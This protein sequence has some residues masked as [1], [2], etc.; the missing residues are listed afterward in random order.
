[1]S[2]M[3]L[4]PSRLPLILI[5]LLALG[6][7]LT[8]AQDQPKACGSEI[9]SIEVNQT[10]LHYFECGKGE[11]L[12]FVHGGLGDLHAFQ[13]QVQ[14]FATSFRVIA[15]SRR[16]YVPNSPH[17]AGDKTNPFNTH[18]ADLAALART[19]KATPA[20]VVA[21][22]GGAYIALGLA[23]EQPELVRSL[24]LGEPPVLPL[25]SRTSVGDAARK[26]WVTR[27]LAPAGQALDGGNVEEGLR[28]FF[29]GL[30]GTP[31][32]DGFPQA[33]RTEL[34]EKDGP[35]FRSELLMDVSADQ[36]SLACEKLGELKCPTLLV[37]GER[38]PAVLLMVTAELERCLEGER[39]VMVPDAGHGMHSQN[40]AFYNQT[41]MPFLQGR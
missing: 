39:Q 31:C 20:H 1:M 40:V 3:T 35:A 30:C 34:I 19:L 26:S 11:P 29:N 9:R 32:F 23:V 21:H 13:R 14:E 18:I 27:V 12:I 2:R 5:A 7:G 6:P 33:R 22:S 24:V 36:P 15:Y 41:V 37:T 17:R 8:D 25:L 10:T 16:Y 4:A 28:R 38:S